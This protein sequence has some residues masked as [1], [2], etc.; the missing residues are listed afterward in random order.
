MLLLPYIHLQNP[1]VLVERESTRDGKSQFI[2]RKEKS[3]N[4]SCSLKGT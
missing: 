4:K 3:I 1:I 2:R